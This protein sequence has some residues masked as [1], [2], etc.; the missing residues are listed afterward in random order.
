ML[1]SM[2]GIYME[3]GQYSD[4]DVQVPELVNV[5]FAQARSILGINERWLKRYGMVTSSGD[6]SRQCSKLDML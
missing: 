6:H 1:S 2:A 4:I 3:L 5:D